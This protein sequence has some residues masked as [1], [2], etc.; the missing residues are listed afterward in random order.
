[1]PIDPPV[2]AGTGRRDPCPSC[3]GRGWEL[4]SYQ[5]VELHSACSVCNGTRVRPLTI[6]AAS[7]RR[8][9]RLAGIRRAQAR[10]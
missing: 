8:A 2:Y 9:G 7:S 1:M 4:R 6:A 10:R 5:G 3:E